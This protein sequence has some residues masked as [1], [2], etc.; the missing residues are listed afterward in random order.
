MI[1]EDE[2]DLTADNTV[3]TPNSN[4]VKNDTEIE[5]EEDEEIEVEVIDPASTHT[6]GLE[7]DADTLSALYHSSRDNSSDVGHVPSS[8]DTDDGGRSM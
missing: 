2:E 6:T 4:T 1:L 5:D 7:A 8:Q 3:I